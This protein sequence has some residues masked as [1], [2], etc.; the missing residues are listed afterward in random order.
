MTNKTKWVLLA[1]AS[2]L[3]S[4][5]AHSFMLSEWLH[6]RYLLGANDGL[7]QMVPFKH[8][9]Y[10]AMK[11][12]H[13]FYSERFGFGGG[14]FS[15]LGY[16]FSTS[17]AFLL[18]AAVTACLDWA[19]AVQ[20]SLTYWADVTVFVSIIRLAMIQLLAVCFFRLVGLRTPFAYL[21]A[22]LYSVSILYFRH[23]VYWEFFADAMLF[24][25]LLL[26]GAERI[27]RAGKP[28]VFII[29][30]T[31]SMADNFYFAYINFLVTFIYI[32][33]RWILPITDQ[34]VKKRRQIL[35]FIAGGLAGALMSLPFFVP[36]VYGYLNNLR[37]P[38]EGEIPL[39]E[40]QENFLTNGRIIVLPAFLVIA[41]LL[42]P[43]Y[44]DRRF[45]LF[46]VLTVFLT[47]LH[48]SP[49]IGSLFNGLSAPQYRWEHMLMLAAGG[50]AAWALQNW[51][52]VRLSPAMVAVIG[53]VGLYYVFSEL[54]IPG[55]PSLYSDSMIT[56]MVVICA[57]VLLA[58]IRYFKH[59]DIA[60]YLVVIG[61]SL[62]TVTLFQQEKLTK[63][64]DA[65]DQVKGQGIP[66]SFFSSDAYDP[67][68]AREMIH[69]LA[70]ADEDPLARFDW[71][72]G[73]RNNT[74][75]VQDFLGMSM[76]SS[77]LNR[78]LLNFYWNDLS[79]DMGRESVSRYA[80]LGGR[81]NLYSL[82]NGVYAVRGEKGNP[83]P[84]EFEETAEQDGYRAYVSGHRL[85]FIRT[86]DRVFTEQA[87]AGAPAI[88]REH[89][90]L[91]GIVL[92]ETGP[93]ESIPEAA[94]LI[95]HAAIET[96]DAKYTG[97]TL[98]VTGDTGGLDLHISD[99]ALLKKDTYVSFYLKRSSADKGFVLK[100]N[101]YRTTR[102]RTDSIY[103]TRVYDL[104]IRIP[105]E[106][107]IRIRMPKG[108]YTFR[109]LE[110]YAEDYTALKQAEQRSADT[111]APAVD[112]NGG[113]FR[114]DLDNPAGDAYAVIPVPYEKGWHARVNGKRTEILKA[115]YA[116]TGIPI[117]AGKNKIE[118]TY[119]P[120]YFRISIVVAL[121][122]AA[123][124]LLLWIRSRRNRP[125]SS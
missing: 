71:M 3:V 119:Y 43:L 41:L 94:D 124:L 64:N 125:L 42:V 69:E 2:L 29:A 120:P 92:D 115:N 44:K 21:G 104:T 65:V 11:D 96:V 16:Y 116:F 45:R 58:T 8:F 110:L 107:V 4:V 19:G 100:V 85:P 105:S 123:G 46:A 74:P 89:A 12:G 49:V 35:Q 61:A 70:E 38:Y 54:D 14:I 91:A 73:T 93:S 40:I 114:A 26:I 101:D 7:S 22:V 62:V 78:H 6:G 39:F 32:V 113:H 84:Y 108:T 30:V 63:N 117:K 55:K 111:P 122:T 51:K 34:E 97:D 37:P 88:A 15:Q 52:Q 36:A 112:W 5:A 47:V 121:A 60:L 13:Y 17:I 109:D 72:I 103:R 20:P 59:W 50:T 23:V 81:A 87:L 10:E 66:K 56:V 28:A 1:A 33:F 95:S 83:I 98:T 106:E 80:G 24:L 86:A 76:Y 9:L 53:T 31:L 68:P 77:L 79:I 27:M 90:M 75:I 102:K 99:R 25:P 67:E 57:I 18:T 118:L 82:L 48:M